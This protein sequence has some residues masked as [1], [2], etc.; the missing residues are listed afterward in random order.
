MLPVA[1]AQL[2]ADADPRR[3]ARAARGRRAPVLVG[4]AGALRRARA[5]ARAARREPR[6]GASRAPRQAPAGVA[7]ERVLDA[8]VVEHADDH[9]AHVV[10]VVAGVRERLDSG[11]SAPLAVAGVERREARRRGRRRRRARGGCAP[12]GPRP[13]SCRRRCRRSSSASSSSPRRAGAPPARPPRRRGRARARAPGAA[14]PRRPARRARSASD[15]HE[16]VEEA[17]DHGGGCA[18]TNSSTTA[19]SLKA[20]TA[21]MPWMPKACESPG[22]RRCRA[23]RARPCPRAPAAACSSTGV[24]SRHGPHHSAQKSTTTGTLLRALDDLALEV[25]LGDVDDGHAAQ[26]DRT[27]PRAFQ[28]PPPRRGRAGDGRPRRAAARPDRDAPLRRHGLAARWSAPATASSPTTRAGTALGRRRRSPAPTTTPTSRPTSL[29][30]LDERG[31]RARR[32]RRRLDGRPHGAALRA[33]AARARRRPGRRHARLRPGD[34]ARTRRRWRAGTRSPT[35]CARA[36][37]RG[38]SRPTA[39]RRGARGL[40]RDVDDGPAPA[41]GRARAPAT[42]SPTRCAWCRARGRSTA[43]GDARAR[44]PSRPSSSPTATRPTPGHPLAVGEAYAADDP[45]RRARRRGAGQSPDRLAGRPAL[46]GHRRRRGAGGLGRRLG[47]AP[48]AEALLGGLEHAGAAL[49][50]RSARRRRCP[51]SSGPCR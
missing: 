38:S 40:A 17:L 13:G 7:R 9:A 29:A 1:N 2:I 43:L 44:S 34:V 6:A 48:V 22:W 27:R 14:R 15:G 10:A 21:G 37:S 20:L 12:R 28:R 50:S 23:W 8:E 16:A 33:R 39:T 31:H 49:P 19:P 11:S 47:G 26:S 42:P 45:R 5:R 51:G 3:A 4:A 46:A 36:A 25:V 18:P 30:V 35:G 32:A 24:S 41:P